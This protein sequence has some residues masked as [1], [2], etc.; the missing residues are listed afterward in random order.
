VYKRQLFRSELTPKGA[1]YTR[2]A[3]FPFAGN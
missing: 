1:I 2:L 3:T